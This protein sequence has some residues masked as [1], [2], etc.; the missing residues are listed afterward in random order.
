M[1]SAAAALLATPEKVRLRIGIGAA[2]VLVLVG[3]AVAV[4][5]TA[6]GPR[7]E[8]LTIEP[9]A[10][11]SAAP[12]ATIYVHVHGAVAA[13]GLFELP[14]G[15]RVV[16]AIAAAGGFTAEA[17]RAA[18]NLARFVEDGEQL[19]VPVA[20]AAG[21]ATGTP[22][23]AADG[24]VN[25]NTADAA[26]LETLPRVGPAM[27]ARIIE[28]REANGRFTAIEDLLAVTGIGE[29]TLEGLRELVTV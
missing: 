15:S 13:P 23:V 26:A 12:T 28:W 14:Q 9:D 18:V 19:G 24:R 11:A 25:L 17:D 1:S 6:L 2:I 27:S 5:V 29:K 22:G 8:E 4:L 16:D 20:G 3:L 7:G 21:E 10:A